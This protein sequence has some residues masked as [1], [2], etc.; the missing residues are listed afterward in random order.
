MVINMTETNALYKLS[1][2]YMLSRADYPISTNRLSFFLLKNNYTDYFTFQQGLGELLDDGYVSKALIHGKTMYSV[3]EEGRNTIHMLKKEISENMRE[4]IDAYI[5]ENKLPIHEDY[6][7]Q[8]H[9]YQL[10][11]QH[12]IANLI[13]EEN[14]FKILEMN[15]ATATEDEAELICA[16]WRES[17]EELYPLLLSRLMKK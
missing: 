11:L 3:T 15:V 16:N 17:S 8:S 2:L 13:I 5:K 12:Y 6:A 10:D 1:T 4:D 9:S 7:V 14:G